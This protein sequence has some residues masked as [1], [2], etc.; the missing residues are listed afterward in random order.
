MNPDW[1]CDLDPFGGFHGRHSIFFN[2]SL[3]LSAIWS[4]HANSK[5]RSVPLGC[6]LSNLEFA[7]DFWDPSL[8]LSW[9]VEFRP[10]F[11]SY[12]SSFLV[13]VVSSSVTMPAY[14]TATHRSR[15]RESWCSSRTFGNSRTAVR[16]TAQPSVQTAAK[17]AAKVCRGVGRKRRQPEERISKTRALHSVCASAEV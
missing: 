9:L 13:N 2:A 12:T 10:I 8:K 6:F 11:T 3:R 5:M 7:C 1:V 16:A 15:P 14:P 17:P 4:C